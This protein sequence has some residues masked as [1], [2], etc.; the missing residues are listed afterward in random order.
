MTQQRSG[1][2]RSWFRDPWR[3]CGARSSGDGGKLIVVGRP[4]NSENYNTA[5]VV[6]ADGVL[7]GKYRMAHIAEGPGFN[8][9]FYYWPGDSGYPVFQTLIGRIGIA[10]CHDRNFPEVFRCLALDGAEIVFVPTGLTVSAYQEASNFLDIPQQAA[11]MANGIFTVCVNRV[12]PGGCA[13]PDPEAG[14]SAEKLAAC[15]AS[16]VTNPFGKI[17]G[18]A[19]L[20]REDLAIVDIDPAEVLAAR[21]RRPF[22]RDRRPE[23]YMRLTAF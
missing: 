23:T 13:K 8:E 4:F 19:A 3:W 17:V 12:G 2:N 18:R 10:T 1:R 14:V 5:F 7:K 22:F 11:S 21:H 16:L 9:N 15:G 6:D 20:E